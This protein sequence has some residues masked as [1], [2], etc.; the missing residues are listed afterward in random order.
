[1]SK[2]VSMFDKN[3]NDKVK[4]VSENEFTKHHKYEE[5]EIDCYLSKA[6]DEESKKHF[7]VA[8]MPKIP[9]LNAI[10]IQYPMVFDTEE[11]RNE[12]FDNFN[13]LDFMEFILDQMKVQI[14]AAR[15]NDQKSSENVSTEDVYLFDDW[16]KHM[17]SHSDYTENE[18]ME[19]EPYYE[20]LLHFDMNTSNFINFKKHMSQTLI[21]KSEDSK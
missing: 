3:N 15:E 10:H 6:Y 7:L 16:V 11:E 5:K 2:V 19:L 13:A 18:I 1:M 8:S 14:E 4:L 20:N 12:F 9:E 17:L 21:D